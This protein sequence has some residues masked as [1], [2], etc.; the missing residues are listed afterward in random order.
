MISFT[1]YQNVRWNNFK[2]PGIIIFLVLL[3]IFLL[4]IC[5]CKMR[6]RTEEPD[7]EIVEGEIV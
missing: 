7:E 2:D 4:M 3:F 5:F 1:L 6:E